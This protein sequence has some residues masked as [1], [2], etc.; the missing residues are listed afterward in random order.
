MDPA[1]QPHTLLLLPFAPKA[2][3]LEPRSLE[4]MTAAMPALARSSR[5]THDSGLA[6]A[7]LRQPRK[8]W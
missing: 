7:R 2:A 1:R 8:I 6:C 3:P 4:P 5:R